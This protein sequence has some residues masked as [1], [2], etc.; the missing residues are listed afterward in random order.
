MFRPCAFH[1]KIG[2]AWRD[3]GGLRLQQHQGAGSGS[4]ES[5]G[6]HGGLLDEAFWL[7]L[8]FVEIDLI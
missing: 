7:I 8:H 6:G 2:E 3:L 1:G 5:S 4:D